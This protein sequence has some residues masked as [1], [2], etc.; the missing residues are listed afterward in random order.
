MIYPDDTYRDSFYAN[1]A[2]LIAKGDNIRLQDVAASYTISNPGG[3]FKT[4]KFYATAQNLGIIW[5]ANKFGI[6]PDYGFSMPAPKTISLGLN[7]N[8]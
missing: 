5:K 7:V 1:S 2:A 6:D 8:F 4:I 3:Y